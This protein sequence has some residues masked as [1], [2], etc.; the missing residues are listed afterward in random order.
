MQ[1]NSQHSSRPYAV[2]LVGAMTIF[3]LAPG[4]KIGRMLAGRELQEVEQKWGPTS[5]GVRGLPATSM[6]KGSFT[7]KKNPLE[8]FSNKNKTVVGEG[9]TQLARIMGYTPTSALITKKTHRFIF[10]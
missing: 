4:L 7:Q 3:Q 1:V 10:L 5:N 6:A 8:S 9:G 2:S